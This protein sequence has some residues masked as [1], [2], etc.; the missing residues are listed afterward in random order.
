MLFSCLDLVKTV[1]EERPNIMVV[2]LKQIVRLKVGPGLM[3]YNLLRVAWSNSKLRINV[4]FQYI[5]TVTWSL[6]SCE[7][8]FLRIKRLLFWQYRRLKAYRG[9]LWDL[10]GRYTMYI[11]HMNRISGQTT[12]RYELW[13]VGRIWVW[14]MQSMWRYILKLVHQR[15]CARK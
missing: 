8:G 9:S 6:V 11:C 3:T 15:L 4:H 12:W 5:E 7:W 10:K 2:K 13:F 1:L 14:E